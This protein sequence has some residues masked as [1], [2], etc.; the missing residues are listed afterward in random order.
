MQHSVSCSPTWPTCSKYIQQ[1]IFTVRY[2][3]TSSIYYKIW[4]YSNHSSIGHIVVLV[5]T[6]QYAK[7]GMHSWLTTCKAE[8][9]TYND[10]FYQSSDLKW[11]WRLTAWFRSNGVNH[12]IPTFTSISQM[13]EKKSYRWRHK[14]MHGIFYSQSKSR[15]NISQLALLSHS[16][17]HKQALMESEWAEGEVQTS[18]WWTFSSIRVSTQNFTALRHMKKKETAS[19]D[20]Q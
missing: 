5:H 14:V 1:E 17:K 4:G 15:L 16:H 19:E 20:R 8:F 2:G 7:H 9:Q 13:G 6:I 10:I 18:W 12:N 11:H 3:R